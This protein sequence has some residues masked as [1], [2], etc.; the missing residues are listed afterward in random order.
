VAGHEGKAWSCVREGSGWG[1]EKGSSPKG[2]Q[3]LGARLTSTSLWVSTLTLL[4][5]SRTEGRNY[6][7]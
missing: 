7:K 4:F 5:L 2:S 3:A 1:S 6:M